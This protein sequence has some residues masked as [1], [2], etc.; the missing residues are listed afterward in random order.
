[1]PASL[2][3]LLK[4]A[5]KVQGSAA[6]LTAN[7]P[8]PVQ[9][10]LAQLLGYSH[11]EQYPDLD[12]HLQLLL[13]IRKLKGDSALVSSDPV[14]DRRHFSAEIAAITGKPT[15]VGEVK[16]LSFPG[17]A[18]TLAARLYVP[19]QH[20]D[21]TVLLVFYH[22]GGFVVGDL[23]TH[24]EACRILCKYGR[25]KVLSTEYRLAPEH[26][27]PA[28]VNDCIAAL[29]WAKAHA[30]DW[31]VDPM[32]I[33]VG[34]DSAGG[35][36]AT[37]VSQQTKGTPDAPFAQL[38]IYP[39]V[40]QYHQYPSQQEFAEGLFLSSS[41]ADNAT[42]AYILS[43]GL[44]LADPIVTPM[45]GDMN[46]LPPALIYTATYDILRDEAEAYAKRLK[47]LGNTVI[48]H[49]I[50]DQ[51]HGFINISPINKGAKRA[52]IRMAKDFHNFMNQL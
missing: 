47:E 38:L 8:A 10:K 31:G 16:N 19:H 24:D 23:D 21:D 17:E 46:G 37:T 34:G 18:G 35:N 42:K 11:Q 7:I 51:G 48:L 39:T 43:G 52:T 4:K 33:A 2:K 50:K 30:A 41:D 40:D 6:R 36:L 12:P 13:A 22:G 26:P 25:F 9:R 14:K 32:R 20:S 29:K 5:A 44:T 28:A 15:P 45:M 3:Q 1:M 49:R 27:A